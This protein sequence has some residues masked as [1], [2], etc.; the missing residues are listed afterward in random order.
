MFRHLTFAFLCVAALA[1][2]ALSATLNPIITAPNSYVPGQPTA[3][4]IHLPSVTNLGAYNIDLVLE[5][6]VGTAGVDFFFDVAATMAASTKYVFPSTTNYFDAATIDSP[7][8]HR[9]TLTDFAFA[10]TNVAAGANDRVAAVVLRTAPTFRSPLSVSV[11]TPLLLLDTPD[12]VPTS[13]AEFGAIKLAVA[14]AGPIE[15]IAVPEPAAALVMLIGIGL[16]GFRS[17]IR[18]CHRGT[19]A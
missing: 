13:V 7:Q 11:S 6:N 14:A 8:R 12:V 10:G 5:A 9:I 2:S 15:L 16:I 18:R 1:S 3:I 17:T 4:D 19:G